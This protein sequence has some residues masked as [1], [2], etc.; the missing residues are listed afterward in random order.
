LAWCSASL[1][2]AL[3]SVGVAASTRPEVADGL[4]PYQSVLDLPIIRVLAPH[5]ATSL[6]TVTTAAAPNIGAGYAG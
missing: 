5:D 6:G 4:A 2:V 1:Y 3:G